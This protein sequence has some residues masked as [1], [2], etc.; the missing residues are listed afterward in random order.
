MKKPRDAN[1]ARKQPNTTI[2]GS[3]PHQP[4]APHHKRMLEEES[5]IKPEVIEARGYRTVTTKAEL[6][7]L[8]FSKAQQNVP[9]LLIPIYGV[10]GELVLYQLRPDLPRIDKKRGK[11]IKYETPSN[12]KM[13]LDVHP[14]ARAKLADPKEPLFISEGIKKGDALVSHDLC[15]IA[16]IGVWS[17]R[18]ANEHGGKTVLADWEY[19]ALNGRKVYIVFDSD[20]MEKKEVYGALVRLK[21]FLESRGANG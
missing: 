16:L 21:A 15:S 10:T 14:F 5:G 17:F 6:A 13:V 11:P 8:G 20:V 1:G 7:K 4:L 2:I 3:S 9:S 19:I 18:G 12:S